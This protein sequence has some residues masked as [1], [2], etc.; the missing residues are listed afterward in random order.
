MRPFIPQAHPAQGLPAAAAGVLAVWLSC[1]RWCAGAG[2]AASQQP[3]LGL[4]APAL[5]PRRLASGGRSS[6]R[7]IIAALERDPMYAKSTLLY[8]LY[9]RLG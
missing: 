6:L 4:Q 3:Q 5:Q 2:G 1:C 8:K 7:H 9:E